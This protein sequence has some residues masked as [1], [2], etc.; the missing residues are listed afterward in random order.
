MNFVSTLPALAWLGL[1][2]IPVGIILLYF[3]KLRRQPM[4][5]PSTFLWERTIEDLHVNSLLQRL[6]NNILLF[7]QLLFL[8]LAAF[9][10]LRP[11]W[12]GDSGPARRLIFLLD[13][14]ASMA[15]T[16]IASAGDLGDVGDAENR[17]ELA[18][19]KI[20]QQID[21]MRGN[22]LA[23]LIAFSDRSDILQ[24]FT[25][26]RRRL[27]DAVNGA[28]VTNRPTNMLE[29]LRA[30]AGLAN[31]NR[32]SQAGDVNDVQVADALPADLYIYSDGGFGPVTDFSLGN[33][34]PTYIA[35]G[36]QESS[37][38]AILTF[39]AERNLERP[40]EVQAFA[41]IANL[42]TESLAGSAELYLDNELV[43][44]QRVELEPE[45]ETGLSFE[46]NAADGN[47]LKLVLVIDDDLAID[48]TAFAALTP[49]RNVSVLLVTPG[50]RA[51]EL[52][53]ETEQSS[54]LG[55]VETRL[56]DY[57]ETDEFK[58][59]ADQG[60][61]D[62]IIFDRCVPEKM[63]PVNTMFVGTVP[64]ELWTA[65]EIT[66]PV[67]PIDIDRTHP[68]MRYLELFSLQIVE[69]RTLKAPP[70]SVSLIT[71]D[72]GPVLVLAPRGG[73]QDLVMGF[74]IFSETEAG[75]AFNTDWPVQRSW[76]VFVY[77]L[78][79]NLGGAVDTSSADNARPG[80]VV[81][82]RVDNRLRSVRMNVPSGPQRTLAV[83]PA[84]SVPFA[85]TDDPGFYEVLTESD[86]KPIGIFTVNLFDSRESNLA[87][88]EDI[89]LGYEAIESSVASV[90]RRS[91]MWRWLLLIALGILATEWIIFNRRLI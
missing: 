89:E 35:I 8:A 13:S 15:S 71:A 38:M 1:A 18:K 81:P 55:T 61:D 32:T 72:I 4:I 6:R 7:L 51:L 65:S 28:E 77:N 86:D 48:N 84:G 64:P 3:L 44:A 40:E 20:L 16:D 29:A 67:I 36:S 5:V 45:E 22:D 56:P 46:L 82:V 26:D 68:I 50:N 60:Q 54:K 17:F 43:D 25:S 80:E 49:V 76:P 42:G 88:A 33:L 37:N 19:Q 78:M 27:R 2:A 66:S 34:A 69:G 23:M 87:V 85:A 90:P 70:G 24:E 63:P 62:L 74:E 91:E 59:R 11:G 47:E 52:A 30:A 83:G 39:S 41:S 58:K 10:M 79:R 53:L 57:L 9:S 31:P 12:Q 14:S 75:T 21:A 73:F